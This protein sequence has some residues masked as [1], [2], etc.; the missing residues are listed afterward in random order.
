MDMHLTYP[1]QLPLAGIVAIFAVI[2]VLGCAPSP[3]DS[4]TEAEAEAEASG[5]SGAFEGTCAEANNEQDCAAA[6]AKSFDTC[7]WYE[8]AIYTIDDLSC[9]SPSPTGICHKK[10]ADDGCASQ[11]LG[12]AWRE[13][14][15][16]VEIV[17]ADNE[18]QWPPTDFLACEAADAPVQCECE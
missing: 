2:T 12:R 14:E 10:N 4:E 17:V 5:S 13:V 18:C 16:G 3:G 7:G 11:E 1:F 9:E 8:G 15:G 6:G